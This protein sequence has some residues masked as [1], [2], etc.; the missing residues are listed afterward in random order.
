MFSLPLITDRLRIDRLSAAD[1]PALAAYRSDEDVAR[2]QSWSRPY[3]IEQANDLIDSMADD[4]PGLRGHAVNLALRTDGRL[5]GDVYVHVLADTPHVAEVG[6]T[7]APWA[8]G[9]GL[10]SEAV[11]TIVDALLDGGSASAEA[12]AEAVADV[13]VVKAIAYVDT[14]NTPSLALFDRLGFRR[15]GYL[16][17]SFRATDGAL[18]DEVLFGLT[19]DIWRTPVDEPTVTTEPHPADLARMAERIYEFNVAATGIDDGTEWAAFVR[20]DLGRIVAGITGTLWGDAAEVHVVWV[21]DERRSQ[22]LGTRL[23]AAAEDQLR[24][25]GGRHVF[26]ATHA[27]QAAPFYERHGYERSGTWDDY[28]RGHGQVFL[29]KLLH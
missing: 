28:P 21:A 19:A 13:A 14:R 10:A 29:H 23:L 12:I 8:Q 9:R 5:A 20:D 17:H 11:V 3:S 25:R 26:L 2:W 16:S 15:E 18:A 6:I 22:G 4:M 1:A 7:L 27:F 24:R